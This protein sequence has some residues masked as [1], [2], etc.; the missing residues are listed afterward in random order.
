MCL[1]SIS[2]QTLPAPQQ[3]PLPL[4][5]LACLLAVAAGCFLSELLTEV[6]DEAEEVLLTMVPILNVGIQLEGGRACTQSDKLI[7]I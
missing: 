3:T 7:C 2:W 6:E 5:P 4:P 1:K